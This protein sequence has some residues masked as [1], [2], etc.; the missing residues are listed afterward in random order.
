MPEFYQ[1]L[2]P[3]LPFTYAI[4]AM[5]EA[6]SGTVAENL[7]YDFWHL[8]IFG[9]IGLTLGILSKKPLHPLLEWFNHKFKESGLSE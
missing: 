8:A 4:G 1:I 9:A 5:R 3:F 6:I 2:Q 7:F